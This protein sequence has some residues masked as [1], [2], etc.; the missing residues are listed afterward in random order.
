MKVIQSPHE[1]QQIRRALDAKVIV[2]LVPTMGAL[3]AGHGRLLQTARRENDFVI[4]SLF[5]NPTQFNNPE[6][7][8]KYPRTLDADLE[9]AQKHEVDAVWTP[10]QAL[11][12]PDDYT[13]KM[14][15]S[16]LSRVLEGEHRPG[17]FDGV[18]SVVAKLFAVTNPTHAY[19]GEKDFQQLTL[20]QKMVEAFFM[21]VQVI[22]VATVRESDGLAMSSRNVRLTAEERKIAPEIYRVLTEVQDDLEAKKQLE[23]KGFRVE[24]IERWQNRRLLAA[25][26]GAVRLID[27]V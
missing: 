26:L 18:L 5:V 13:F 14:T 16:A 24:Y 12:Y 3:H 25:Q 7:L 21:P 27:N 19:F 6:D 15:E 11:M 20:I 10:T 8:K 17:H 9:W 2:G 1:M 23:A 22:P 4:L